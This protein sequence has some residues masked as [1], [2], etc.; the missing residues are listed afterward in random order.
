MVG[1]AS[2]NNANIAQ[3]T[4]QIPQGSVED[5]IVS[6]FDMFPTIANVTGTSYSHNVDGVDL[7]P[8]LKAEPGSHRQQDLLI[9]FPH[10]HRAEY[11]TV[12]REGDWKLIYNYVTDDFELYNLVNDI[13]ESNNLYN[14]QPNRVMQMARKMAQ[15]LNDAG[16]Q[17]PEFSNGQDDPFSMP[18]LPN[19]DIDGDGI[20]DNIEDSNFNGL[21][22]AVLAP[23]LWV[24]TR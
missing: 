23:L 10:D 1:W 19:V 11:F 7:S 6:V 16:A 24:V 2:P 17:W 21:V 12:Y 20:P 13:S 9:H 14:S 8:Y 4:L 5:D 18:N 15:E 3:S 22:D